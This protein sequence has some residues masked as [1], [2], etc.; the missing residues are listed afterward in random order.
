MSRT[1]RD[2]R[3]TTMMNARARHL[4]GLAIALLGPDNSHGFRDGYLEGVAWAH[5]HIG[6]KSNEEIVEELVYE[7]RRKMVLR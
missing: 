7:W 4:A 2:Q 5:I 6:E 3:R 1:T